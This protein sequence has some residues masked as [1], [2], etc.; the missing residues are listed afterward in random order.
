M[1][2]QSIQ[3]EVTLMIVSKPINWLSEIQFQPDKL[4]NPVTATIAGYEE[5]QGEKGTT[6]RLSVKHENGTT[7]KLDVFGDSL[8]S[9]IDGLGEDS[10]KW[11]GKVIQIMLVKNAKTGK[12]NKKINCVFKQ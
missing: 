12:N 6:R 7:Y 9:L 4:G 1:R 11:N 10:D 8:G 3:R 5:E 2:P